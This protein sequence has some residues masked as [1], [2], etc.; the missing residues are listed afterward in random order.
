MTIVESL[1][2]FT[3]KNIR[4]AYVSD[5]FPNY[6]KVQSLFLTI[7]D[8]ENDCRNFLNH[9]NEGLGEKT[10]VCSYK[11]LSCQVEGRILVQ[12]LGVN[13]FWIDFNLGTCSISLYYVFDD[14]Q[15]S[16]LNS[17]LKIQII[18]L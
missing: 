16:I 2:R 18:F 10:M 8:F 11:L 13:D 6:V 15:V 14:D 1:L 4:R 7:K 9:L 12:P 5:W 17:D 3:N